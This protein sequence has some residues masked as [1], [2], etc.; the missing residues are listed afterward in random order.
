MLSTD[1]IK[2]SAFNTS[3]TE[4]NHS[5]ERYDKALK[6]LELEKQRY[7]GLCVSLQNK[8]DKLNNN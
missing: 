6:E 3:L 8:L 7:N 1:K 5:K 4:M 2:E